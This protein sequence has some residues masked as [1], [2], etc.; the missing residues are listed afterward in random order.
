MV[1][2]KIKRQ[3]ESKKEILRYLSMTGLMVPILLLSVLF[4]KLVMGDLTQPRAVTEAIAKDKENITRRLN[5]A[6]Y[7]FENHDAR[8]I[9]EEKAGQTVYNLKSVNGEFDLQGIHKIAFML[10]QK[11][12][13]VFRAIVNVTDKI[14]QKEIKKVLAKIRKKERSDGDLYLVDDATGKKTNLKIMFSDIVLT[15]K[16]QPDQAEG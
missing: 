4:V 5:L 12:P 16:E 6:F 9:A 1:P 3:D 14:S 11:Y 2:N 15:S 10:K 8:I 7:L 13:E